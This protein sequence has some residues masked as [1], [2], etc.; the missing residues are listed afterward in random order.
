MSQPERPQIYLISPPAFDSQRFTNV[1]QSVFDSVQV[2]CLRRSLPSADE[3]GLQCACDAVRDVSHARDI[4]V[5]IESHIQ[6]VRLAGLDGVHLASGPRSVRL[7]RAELGPDA[8][9]GAFCGSSRHEGL[10]AAEAGADYVS[11]G[12]VLPASPGEGTHADHGLFA[13]WSE[14]IEM[15]AV[16]EG[17]LNQACV[18]TLAPVTDFFGIGQEIWSEDD[19]VSAIKRLAAAIP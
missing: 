13:W 16:A 5:V 15:P 14:M 6:M 7:A 12:P 3:S 19:P 10:T 9:V 1:L 8:I 18:K 2:A 11:F 4:P 17:A